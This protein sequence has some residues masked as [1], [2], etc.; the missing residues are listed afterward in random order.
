VHVVGK[1]LL[2]NRNSLFC[3]KVGDYMRLW[4][5][6]GN[7]H[8]LVRSRQIDGRKTVTVDSRR[9]LSCISRDPPFYC[10]NHCVLECSLRKG[11][12]MGVSM[13]K[14]L[15]LFFVKVIAFTLNLCRKSFSILW[16]QLTI[17]NNVLRITEAALHAGISSNY[18]L[19]FDLWRP[20]IHG[21]ER[22]SAESN[23]KC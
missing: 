9:V 23:Y 7:P 6:A 16:P 8:P 2:F 20:F 19:I 11:M 15:T 22:A 21:T 10:L 1:T 3:L 12:G 14:S 17:T 18:H 5:M 13:R 4:Q